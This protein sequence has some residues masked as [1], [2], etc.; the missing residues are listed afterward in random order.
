MVDYL[1]YLDFDTNI[2]FRNQD[3]NPQ[4]KE[5]IFS[6]TSDEHEFSFSVQRLSF[7]LFL[8]RSVL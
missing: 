7:P 6:T 5:W 2:N 4:F 3:Y 1:D 8:F